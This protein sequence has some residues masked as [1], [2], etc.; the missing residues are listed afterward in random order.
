MLKPAIEFG[1][2]LLGACFLSL[3]RLAGD[4]QTLQRR[5]R[6]GFGVA[7][8]R[9]RGGEFGL[10]RRGL[11]LLAGARGNDAHSFILAAVCIGK[12]GLRREPSQVEQQRL[13][14]ADLRGDIPVADGLPCLG[15]QGR[16]LG[17][18]LPDHILDASQVVFGCLEPQF[19]LVAAG[20][21]AG[22]TGG[23]FK[24]PAA[25]IRPRLDD[26]A[27]A[28]LMHQR[29]RTRARRGVRE[30]HGNVARPHLAAVD[31][32]CRALPR[33]QCGARLPASSVS[34][35]AAGAL[36]SLLSTW[37]ATSAW[38]RPGRSVLPEKITSSISA[39]RIAL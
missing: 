29:G 10:A 23:F 14:A 26:L 25:L 7:R 31:A 22:N 27:D 2:A 13:A 36:R 18:K 24:H 38:F 39:A 35:K 16:N 21:Q 9:Q 1:N 33:G 30:Q 6:P 15:L 19:G 12:F 37:T 34:L 11:R 20:M 5:R 17:G 4:D 32:K 3:E 8:T 28:A